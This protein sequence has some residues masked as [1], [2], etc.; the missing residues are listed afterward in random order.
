MTDFNAKMQ[1]IRFRLGLCPRPRWG[2][3]QRSP[4]PSSWNWGGGCF[5]AGPGRGWAGEEEGKGR[6]RGG[7]EKWRGGKG[8]AL[9]LLLNQ[10]PSE[11]CYA[12]AV[13][14][15]S[16]Q[17]LLRV[18]A[19]CRLT[20]GRTTRVCQQNYRAPKLLSKTLASSVLHCDT[21]PN[22]TMW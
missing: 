16:L 5:M 3:L 8:R 18:T 14:S 21:K 6:G 19:G 15:P 4:R 13:Y 1:Q 11:P 20:S 12:T 17:Y 7:R 22:V 9:K 10:G 2:S